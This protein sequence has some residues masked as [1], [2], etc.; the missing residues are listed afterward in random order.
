M[1]ETVRTRTIAVKAQVV[2]DVLADYGAIS[3]WA[4]NVDHSC[5]LRSG[6]EGPVGTTRRIQAGRN[7][8]V[9]RIVEH[10]APRALGYD[11]EG[12]PKRLKTVRNRWTLVPDSDT[13]TVVTLTTTVEIGPRPPQQLGERVV[14]RVL[15]K[16]S[17]QMLAGLA[18]LLE[19]RSTENTNAHG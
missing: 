8:V 7:T 16:Q 1:T 10:D 4:T 6:G 2:W 9:E 5:L 12:L 18:E 11:I 3:S 13:S 15:A 19:N 14:G 17:E